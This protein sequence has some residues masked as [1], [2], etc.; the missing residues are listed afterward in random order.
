MRC[1]TRCSGGRP[2][3][4]AYAEPASR[5]GRG[6]YRSAGGRLTA[7]KLVQTTLVRHGG[8]W[9]C[10]RL[11][12]PASRALKC[13]LS[14]ARPK[15]AR[16]SQ[17][18]CTKSSKGAT[19]NAAAPTKEMSGP[20]PVVACYL[21][22]PPPRFQPRF[23]SSANTLPA[24]HQPWNNLTALQIHFTVI[25]KYSIQLLYGPNRNV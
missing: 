13:S 14:R 4:H 6:A 7:R 21:G 20:L 2:N 24:Q 19:V 11:R 18:K 25:Y 1:S 9:Q 5:P 23:S 17:R 3:N 22:P 12:S 16:S 15:C 8:S 10:P